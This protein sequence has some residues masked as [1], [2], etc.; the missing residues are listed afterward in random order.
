MVKRC[1]AAGVNVITDFVINHMT[2]PDEAG[3][4]TAGSNFNG[5][6]KDYPGVPFSSLDF[7]HCDISNWLVS[8]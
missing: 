2:R 8:V 7:H 6:N 3:T 5:N 1:N 4:G